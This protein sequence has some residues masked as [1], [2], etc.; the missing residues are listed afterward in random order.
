MYMGF[1]ERKKH[2]GLIENEFI[3]FMEKFDACPFE[4][5]LNGERFLIGEG[6]PEFSVAVHKIPSIGDL[7]TSTSITLGEA[8]M[9][10]KRQRKK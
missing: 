10:G 7:M 6:N 4:I 5:I 1:G 3:K 2:M 9:N 8:Y